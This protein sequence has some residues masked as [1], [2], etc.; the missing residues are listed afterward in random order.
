MG[1]AIVSRVKVL[2][3]L[4][5]AE[6]RIPQDGRIRLMINGRST[7]FRVVT[8][9]GLHGESVVLRILDRQDLSLDFDSL[10]LGAMQQDSLRRALDRPYGIILVTGPTGSGKTTTLYAAL[11]YLNKPERKVL[12]AEDPIEYTLSG[13]HQTQVRPA[14]GYSFA[15]ALRS[16]L[17][18]DP[19]VIMVGEVRDRETAEVAVQASLTGHLLLSTL[20][21]N[22]AAGAVTRLLDMGVADYLLASTLSLVV[23]QRLV[24]RLCLQCRTPTQY[25]QSLVERLGPGATAP[26]DGFRAVGCS[27]CRGTGYAGRTALLEIMEVTTDLQRAMLTRPDAASLE[28]AAVGVG[29]E[30]LLTQGLTHVAHGTTT[31]EEVLRVTRAAA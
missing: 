17:R 14:I 21:T 10:G 3:K 4:N 13:I 1:P 11:Q 12:T 9:P 18:Q 19:D 26:C 27:A 15:T 7:D 6:R 22:S 16:F 24:R 25:E 20:H 30:T 5:I 28:Q 8:S 29:M 23:G 31:L 2:A